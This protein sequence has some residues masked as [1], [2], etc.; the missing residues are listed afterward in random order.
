MTKEELFEKNTLMAY[1][2]ANKYRTNYHKEYEEIL[3]K[4]LF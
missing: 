2:I 4:K 3:N 1:K